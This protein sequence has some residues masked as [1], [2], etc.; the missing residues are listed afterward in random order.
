MKQIYKIPYGD[1]LVVRVLLPSSSRR[2]KDMIARAFIVSI[3]AKEWETE[4]EQ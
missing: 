2:T 1:H 4:D 3:D